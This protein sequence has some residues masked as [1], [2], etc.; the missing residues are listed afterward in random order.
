[1]SANTSKSTDNT[2]VQAEM[3]KKMTEERKGKR[4]STETNA[5][6]EEYL[7]CQNKQLK[8]DVMLKQ[9]TEHQKTNDEREKFVRVSHLDTNLENAIK[10]SLAKQETNKT[11]LEAD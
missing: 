8:L 6:R 3:S 5:N 1:M 9:M 4:K 2:E 10:L 11:N 7:K